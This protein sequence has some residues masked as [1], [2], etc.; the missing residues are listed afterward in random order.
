M[1]PMH[2]R[3]TDKVAVQI[4]RLTTRSIAFPKRDLVSRTYATMK[5]FPHDY[6]QLRPGSVSIPSD[7][8]VNDLH[9]SA[10]I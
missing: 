8:E 7:G 5:L 9:R 2:G 3:L 4:T 1:E 6:W 10:M